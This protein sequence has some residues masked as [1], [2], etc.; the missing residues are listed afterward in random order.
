MAHTAVSGQFEDAFNVLGI[1]DELPPA[2]QAAKKAREFEEE[3]RN[4][5][6]TSGTKSGTKS[7]GKQSDLEKDREKAADLDQKIGYAE[8]EL[9]IAKT[10]RDETNNKTDSKGNKT[11]TDSQKQQADLQVKKAEDKL[12]DLKADRAA[13]GDVGEPGASVAGDDRKAEEEVA[14]RPGGGAEQWRPVIAQAL[15][16]MGLSEAL[17]GITVQQID[18]ESGGDPNARN[19][20]DINAQRGDPSIGLLQVI[21][22]TF[23]AM[24]RQFPEANNG[25]P[26]DQAHPLA[27]IVAA[28]GW[29][30]HK[31]G[32]PDNIWPTRNGYATG[33]RVWGPGGPK[34]DKIPAMLSDGE[35]V[36]NSEAT[37][38]NLPILERINSGGGL[39]A[40]AR[41][42]G[43]LSP[44]VTNFRVAP[45]M[46]RH[47]AT[48]GLAAL[49]ATKLIAEAASKAGGAGIAVL[50]GA[51]SGVMGGAAPSGD[52]SV[53]GEVIRRM[54]G[55]AQATTGH[56]TNFAREVGGSLLGDFVGSAYVGGQGGAFAD[57]LTADAGHAVSA[58]N[59]RAASQPIVVATGGGDTKQTTFNLHGRDTHEQFNA[60]RL[61]DWQDKAL[62]HAGGRN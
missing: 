62:T 42:Q 36:V 47:F 4:P 19:G 22:S 45:N 23:T 35:F 48:G 44:G 28:L 1:P 39:P 51:M 52:G 58:A 12:A 2:L 57:M 38:R 32:G 59:M 13:I 11:A 27:N 60:A 5:G 43:D 56:L 29:T 16:R 61:K 3:R 55:A 25:L 33:G 15:R 37:S 46:R 9:A 8:D 30:V 21:R 34:E 14:Y 7:S 53:E 41:A 50:N 40:A 54:A 20:W 6:S 17:A 24:R 49:D 26:D 31:Y 10:R 18:I